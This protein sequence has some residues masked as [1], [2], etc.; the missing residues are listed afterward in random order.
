MPTPAVYSNKTFRFLQKSLSVNIRDI[1][2][3]STEEMCRFFETNL[4]NETYISSIEI[5]GIWNAGERAALP[6]VGASVHFKAVI[7]LPLEVSL[8]LKSNGEIEVVSQC[9]KSSIEYVKIKG[10]GRYKHW[11]CMVCRKEKAKP[12]KIGL[13]SNQLLFAY[14]KETSIQADIKKREYI[15][16]ENA[17]RIN[18]A[19]YNHFDKLK[20]NPLE[21]LLISSELTLFLT[22]SMT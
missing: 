12:F 13:L 9:C 11:A 10:N 15:E 22:R 20:M 4:Q 2:S 21:T 17:A 8:M 3:K 14:Q 6:K 1:N 5:I 7:N 18:N 19:L 16:G